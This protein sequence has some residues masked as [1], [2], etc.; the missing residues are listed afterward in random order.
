M[1]KHRAPAFDQV[2]TQAVEALCRKAQAQRGRGGLHLCP[3]G[4]KHK[5]QALRS[6]GLVLQAAQHGVAAQGFFFRQPHKKGTEGIALQNLFNCP[7]PVL[8]FVGLN[9]MDLIQSHAKLFKHWGEW[10]QWR[11][12]QHQFFL[13][14]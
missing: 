4:A 3:N 13:L 5:T 14:Q 2:H 10:K 8:G 11:T 9:Q 1:F 7:K 12:D 6:R